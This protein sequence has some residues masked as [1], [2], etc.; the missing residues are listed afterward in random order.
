[1]AKPINDITNIISAEAAGAKPAPE[2]DV[3]PTSLQT[4]NLPGGLPVGLPTVGGKFYPGVDVQHPPPPG[5]A[6]P[7]PGS[8][9]YDP[10][11]VK[12]PHEKYEGKVD[13]WGG[14]Q[15]LEKS[16]AT[17]SLALELN[18]AEANKPAMPQGLEQTLR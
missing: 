9:I 12:R 14:G 13:I 3:S 1:M 18:Q 10:F 17:R 16:V 6:K 4:S 11:G 5:F 7:F 8:P 15:D 2:D